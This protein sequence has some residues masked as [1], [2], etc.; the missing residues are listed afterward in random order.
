MSWTELEQTII[1]DQ[2]KDIKDIKTALMGS[3]EDTDSTGLVGQVQD[4]TRFRLNIS[5]KVH[6]AWVLISGIVGKIGYDIYNKGGN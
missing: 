1:E 4:N 5:R 3:P 2:G 6:G